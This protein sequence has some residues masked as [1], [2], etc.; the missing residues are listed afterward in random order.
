MNIMKNILW[1]IC[2]ALGTACSNNSSETNSPS[3]NTHSLEQLPALPKERIIDLYN[4]VDDIDI[5]FEQGFSTS[6]KGE[7]T[8]TN[9]QYILAEQ[10]NRV[11]CT[12]TAFLFIKSQGEEIAQIEAYI[13]E[14]CSYFVIY[15]N[16]KPAYANGMHPQ[17]VQFFN[18]FLNNVQAVPPQ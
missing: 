11:P 8:K 4:R 9:I 12:A 16:G 18:N 10:A 3:S 7:G 14:G 13:G 15:E 17:G 1:I 6:A 5:Q 2:I